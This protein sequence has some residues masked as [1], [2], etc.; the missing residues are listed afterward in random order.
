MKWISVTQRLP[1]I[2]EQVLVYYDGLIYR[3]CRYDY[4]KDNRD[5]ARTRK[6]KWPEKI[7]WAANCYYCDYP[8]IPTHWM[9]LPP[10]PGKES[11]YSAEAT[12]EINFIPFKTHQLACQLSHSKYISEM[13]EYY[14]NEFD[15]LYGSLL[16]DNGKGENRFEF[17]IPSDIWFS[18][19]TIPLTRSWGI[20]KESCESPCQLC[21]ARHKS[22]HEVKK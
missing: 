14:N 10:A 7:I 5:R 13:Y 12:S 4:N 18:E 21:K 3:S 6:D 17:W 1:E 19:R 11:S 22:N 20:K 8:E 2:N 16:I 9:P 15:N